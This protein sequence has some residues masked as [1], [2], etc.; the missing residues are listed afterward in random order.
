MISFTSYLNESANEEK[1]TH[2]EHAEDHP[3]NAGEEGFKHAFNTLH[4]THLA[5]QGKKS[6]V[7]LS[8]KYDGSPSVIFG[9]HPESGR[10]FVASKSVFNKDPKLNYT[11]SDIQKNHG[12]APGL[13]SKLTAALHHLPKVTP[14]RGVYQGDIMHSGLKSKTNSQGD[15]ESSAGS[16]HFKPNT[17]TY[18]AKNGTPEAAKA[19]AA[20]IGVAVHTAY[21]GNKLEDMKAHYNADVSHFNKHPD[22]HMIDT[23]FK[24]SSANYTPDAQKTFEG[25]MKK[26]VEA[27]NKLKSYS[28]IEGGNESHKEHLKTYINQTVRDNS[29]PSV[30]GYKAHV[31][32]KL[33]K[34]VDKVKTDKAK[35]AK[36]ETLNKTVA[37]IDAN[38]PA[39]KSTLEI[40]K[41]LQNAK[42]V[43][44]HTLGGADYAF[45]HS[46]NG[47]SVKPEGHVAVLHNRPTKVVDR[48]EFSAA[49]FAARP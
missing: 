37:H 12:H 36:T 6:S 43:L 11:E 27:N 15:I 8:T 4:G 45:H 34:E 25:H 21:H 17:I 30:S 2:L 14:N 31:T 23:S 18:S 20:K 47:K 40:H 24:P 35:A 26:A 38:K 44:A 29:T 48:S 39:F 32:N 28:H 16:V 3:I 19:K 13:V 46:I 41:H 10:F 5:L 7:S 22:V 1:L 49:N 33:Q 42:N 9:H